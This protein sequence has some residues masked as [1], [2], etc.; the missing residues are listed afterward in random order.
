MAPEGRIIEGV[1][2]IW[3]KVNR[4]S[5]GSLIAL[6]RRQGLPFDLRRVFFVYD[7]PASIERAGHAVSAEAFY[8]AARGSFELEF[9]NGSE[10]AA[11]RLDTPERGVHV[12]EG[13]LVRAR[14][15]SKDSLFLV[16]SSQDF[17]EVTY[18]SEPFFLRD[19]R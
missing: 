12:R 6:D 15:F 8:L 11:Y 18:E 2:A 5:R 4:D 14:D 9:D 3:L 13:V 17:E 10:R 1:E 19:S 16:L 7:V